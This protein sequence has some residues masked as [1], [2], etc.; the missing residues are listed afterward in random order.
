[1]YILHALKRCK[2]ETVTQSLAPS[3][4]VVGHGGFSWHTTI[5]DGFLLVHV[6]CVSDTSSPLFMHVT[7][8]SFTPSPQLV[9]QSPYPS[10]FHLGQSRLL[11][12]W[13]VA[14]F[15]I[16]LQNSSGKV[17]KMP[18]KS[19]EQFTTLCL[20]CFSQHSPLHC[21][22]SLCMCNHIHVFKSF[23]NN[24]LL[25]APLREFHTTWQSIKKPVIPNDARF[26]FYPG[27]PNRLT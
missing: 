4:V 27:S 25:H 14:G 1:M 7:F 5:W 16:S 26:L 3:P 2:H 9:E 17:C 19:A 11:H 18:S 24:Q 21:Y 12:V 15:E 23:I 13:L 8:L 20:Y 6:H 22:M 10:F